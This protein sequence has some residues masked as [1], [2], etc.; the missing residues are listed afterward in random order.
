MKVGRGPGAHAARDPT[1]LLAFLSASFPLAFLIPALREQE[2]SLGWLYK[3]EVVVRTN[4]KRKRAAT[5]TLI[6][7][8]GHTA[9]AES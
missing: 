1:A 4:R 8:V 9:L 3:A 5:E 6:L 2:D 7:S